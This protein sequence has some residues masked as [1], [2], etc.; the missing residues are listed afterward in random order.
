[1]IYS[2]KGLVVAKGVVNP[3]NVLAEYYNAYQ[4]AS[5][6]SQWQWKE[7]AFE[8]IA[9]FEPPTVI[10]TE[11]EAVTYIWDGDDH[12][13]AGSPTLDFGAD[14]WLI[15][16]N[17]SYVEVGDGD[18]AVQWTSEYPELVL[19]AFSFQY[20]REPNT[21]GALTGQMARA[22]IQLSVDGHLQQ[23]TGPYDKGENTSYPYAA[24]SQERTMAQTVVCM[25]PLQAGSHKVT[26]VAAQTDKSLRYATGGD[27]LDIFDW[28]THTLTYDPLAQIGN[29]RMIVIRFPRSNWLRAA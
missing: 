16:D 7:D 27:T 11:A 19:C 12:S 15:P 25:V 23:G 4:I 14:R 21:D 8:D 10:D 26:A 28:F 6:T 3:S 20:V 17:S 29:R 13:D 18:V 5:Q 24:G 1:M 9:S 22:K 2:S